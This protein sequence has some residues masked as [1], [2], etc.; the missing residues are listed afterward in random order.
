MDETFNRLAKLGTVSWR[1]HHWWVHSHAWNHPTVLV[2]SWH[3]TWMFRI[4][5][6]CSYLL[7]Y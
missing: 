1:G 3:M 5:V 4:S 6:Q 7:A 2:D